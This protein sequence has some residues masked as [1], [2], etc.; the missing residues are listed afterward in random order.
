MP[1]AK[2]HLGP[3]VA[4]LCARVQEILKAEGF[5]PHPDKTRVQRKGGRQRVTGLVV[6]EAPEGTPGA[7]VPRE[8]VRQLR[9][10]IHNREKGKPAKEGETL[11]QLKG[12]AA[13]VYMTDE[14][15][16]RAFLERLER[17]EARA[18]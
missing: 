5:T 10:A 7:R 6:N 12:M 3:P 4:V 18:P 14:A 8:V 11:A 16:G 17:L 2:R 1:K 13:F 9:A 15:K